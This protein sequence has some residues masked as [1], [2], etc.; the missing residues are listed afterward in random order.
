MTLTFQ[1]VPSSSNSTD[2]SKPLSK[3]SSKP[4]SKIGFHGRDY[5]DS[6]SVA[7][8]QPTSTHLAKSGSTPISPHVTH[9]SSFTNE[10]ERPVRASPKGDPSF[11]A[12]GESRSKKRFETKNETKTGEVEISKISTTTTTKTTIRAAPTSP[13]ASLPVRAL[14]ILNTIRKKGESSGVGMVGVGERGRKARAVVGKEGGKRG[15]NVKDRL[16]SRNDFDRCESESGEKTGRVGKHLMN[17]DDDEQR[18][19]EDA[20][21]H[22]KD[23][24]DDVVEQDETAGEGL[25]HH[26]EFSLVA[27][28]DD[29]PFFTY[30]DECDDYRD[31]DKSDERNKS[32]GSDDPENAR[33]NQN[34]HFTPQPDDRDTFVNS[35]PSFDGVTQSS[36]L[37]SAS[38][39]MCGRTGSMKAATQPVPTV[40]ASPANT[41]SSSGNV[42]LQALNTPLGV[43]EISIVSSDEEEDVQILPGASKQQ[44]QRSPQRKRQYN[45]VVCG[46]FKAKTKDDLVI[47][48]MSHVDDLKIC[49]FCD[50][51]FETTKQMSD[52]FVQDH[53]GLDKNACSHCSKTFWLERDLNR[54]IERSHRQ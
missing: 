1:D 8:P 10:S 48:V 32:P 41:A 14:G 16:A 45:C 12:A 6:I 44:K 20:D 43:E 30:P 25:S 36:I 26:E 38:G 49:D 47:H 3:P 11:A 39:L 17:N 50:M 2:L 7:S 53:G 52:H 37:P 13:V 15:R 9:R 28:D 27:A 54:H 33:K 46:K 31:S 21:D 22:D 42:D 35:R 51:K 34:L 23:D 29:E 4:S 18:R 40:D 24:N 5:P 19:K